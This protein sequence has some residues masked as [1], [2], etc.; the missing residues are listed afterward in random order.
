MTAVS[1]RYAVA[2]GEGV[3]SAPILA[4][5]MTREALGPMLL[6]LQIEYDTLSR[7]E[8]GQATADHTTRLLVFMQLKSLPAARQ[9]IGQFAIQQATRKQ[10]MK[11][12]IEVLKLVPWIIQAFLDSQ[13]EPCQGTGSVGRYGEV[14][15]TCKACGGSRR[16]LPRPRNEGEIFALYVLDELHRKVGKAKAEMRRLLRT[17]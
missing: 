3:S 17:S 12:D 2:V 16:F 6:R 14:R 10:F 7:Q 11:P 1:E 5:G 13:C 4:A 15:T 8:I 9:A